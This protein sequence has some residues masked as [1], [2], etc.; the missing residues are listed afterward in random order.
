MPISVLPAIPHYPFLP[1]AERLGLALALGLFVGLERERRSKEAGLRTFAFVALLGGL[2]GLL[3]ES[4]T[5][6]M[7][8]LVGL[9]IVFLNLHALYA[10]R[11][12]EL[13]TSAALGL[14][15]VAGVFCGQ[16][17]RL[18]PSALAVVTAALLAWK[19][20]LSGF[21]QALTETELRSAILLAILAFVIYPALPSG[22]VDRWDLIDP[23]AA[24]VIVILIAGV[25]FANYVLLKLYG[26]RGIELTGFLGGLV[27]STVTVTEMATR[28]RDTAGRLED[29]AYRGVLLATVAMLL[30]NMVLL[31]LV[32]PP[33]LLVSWLP[34]ALMLATGGVLVLVSRG[35]PAA[36]PAEAPDLRLESPF[37]IRSALQLGLLFLAL[38]V[39]GTL[40]QRKLGELGFY[41]VSI[42][43]GL[44]SSSSAVASAAALAAQ[45]TLSAWV[46]GIGAL[47]ASLTSAL[48][49]WPLIARLSH[50]P[51]LKRRTAMALVLIS[52]MGF[53]GFAAMQWMRSTAPPAAVPRVVSPLPVAPAPASAEAPPLAP[54]QPSAPISAGATTAAKPV[55]AAPGAKP[56]SAPTAP[57]PG[58]PSAG[59]ASPLRRR[60]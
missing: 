39:A 6:L 1:T 19:R 13:T 41:G 3:G 14:I 57:K 60:R 9:L 59:G 16:G 15:A 51:G 28:V 32:A 35:H 45:G 2:G 40:A 24:L 8:G 5:L 36:V 22:K 58:A 42:G 23:R 11:G 29:V 33:A 37:S 25:G 17:H 54:P 55:P 53:A 26:A 48:V 31:A 49:G 56:A 4:Y 34:F 27:N 44:I 30:R 50:S 7:L 52:M 10:Q 47:L 43:G 21:S 20:P 38:Q 46:A 12:S 18:T